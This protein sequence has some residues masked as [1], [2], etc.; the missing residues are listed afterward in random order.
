MSICSGLKQEVAFWILLT[1]I[2]F[3]GD[4]QIHPDLHHSW[5]RWGGLPFC[6]WWVATSWETKSL[7]DAWWRPQSFSETVWNLSIEDRPNKPTNKLCLFR[8]RYNY[9]KLPVVGRIKQSKRK[10]VLMDWNVIVALFGLVR[11]QHK[12]ELQ[13][14]RKVRFGDIYT[15]LLT[16]CISWID[17]YSK[18]N[19][20]Q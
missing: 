8:S 1:F 2:F 12:R 9:H 10:V 14:P 11:S 6:A 5:Q 13:G 3:D 20:R 17:W 19:D 16:S 15:L 7:Q 4:Q 18:N